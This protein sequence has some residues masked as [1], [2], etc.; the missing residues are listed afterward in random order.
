MRNVPSVLKS[1]AHMLRLFI[2][3]QSAE[4]NHEISELLIQFQN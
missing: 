2:N 1:H 4:D 3:V